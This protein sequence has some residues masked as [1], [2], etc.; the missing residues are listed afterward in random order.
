MSHTLQDVQ[1]RLQERA[2]RDEQQL[3]PKRSFIS[4][5]DPYL[6]AAVDDVKQSLRSPPLPRPA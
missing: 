5:A 1:L 3:T 6:L 2:Q 4:L